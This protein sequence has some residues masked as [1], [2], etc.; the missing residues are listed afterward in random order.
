M[1][2]VRSAVDGKELQRIKN[3]E[4]GIT[5]YKM[6]ME[7]LETLPLYH[8]CQYYR[9]SARLTMNIVLRTTLDYTFFFDV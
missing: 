5:G 1:N 4:R 2:D 9:V 6:Q 7:G 8:N 3:E